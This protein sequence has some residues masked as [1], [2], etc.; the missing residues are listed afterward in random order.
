MKLEYKDESLL[1]ENVRKLYDFV[2][3]H[4]SEDYVK[5]L[6]IDPHHIFVLIDDIDQNVIDNHLVEFI[7]FETDAWGKNFFIRISGTYDEE[8]KDMYSYEKEIKTEKDLELAKNFLGI[9]FKQMY[10]NTDEFYTYKFFDGNVSPNRDIFK[11]RN[12]NA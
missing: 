1:T 11:L 3:D 9:F 4:E 6:M 10:V 8:N 2:K 7:R 5:Y 12:V